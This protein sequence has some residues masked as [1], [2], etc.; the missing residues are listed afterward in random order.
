MPSPALRPPVAER[1][2]PA[3][4]GLLV[5][6]ALMWGLSFLFI[7]VLLRAL[8]PLWINSGR[9]VIGSV[10]L[11]TILRIRG[12]SIP[13]DRATLMH[14][15]VLGTVTNAIPWTAIAW[16]QQS[17]P[18]GLTALIMALVPTSTLIV[19][20]TVRLE[21]LTAP[22]LAGLLLALGG[23]IVILAD[24]LDDTGRLLAILAA[25]GATLLY[26]FGSVYAKRKLSGR[27]RPL[28]I[29]TGQILVAAVVTMPAALL[30]SPP[31]DFARIDGAV[32]ASLL[33][34]GILGTGLAFVVFY[35]L[36]ERVG[37]TNAS[38][39]T[40][41]I[42][43]VAVTAG[44]IILGERLGTAAF[45]GGTLVIAGI[46]LSQRATRPTAMERLESEPR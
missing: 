45:V 34:L 25:V 26:A 32:I 22:R 13:R 27:H 42:P 6:L 24:D 21:R 3:E 20:V 38:M 36:I 40:Y 33:L 35:Q 43:V 14:L 18:S 19:A 16:A 39:V 5:A 30:W 28:A 46:R 23:V 37:A 12:G 8:P 1:F 44:A 9:T 2:T 10:V 31:P 15:L 29:A 11:F 4:V 17:I 41:L 7:N